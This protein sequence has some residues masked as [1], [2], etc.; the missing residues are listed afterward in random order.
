MTTVLVIGANRGIGLEFVKQFLERGDKVLATCRSKGSAGDLTALG[1]AAGQLQVFEVDV[2]HEESIAGLAASLK[3]A[4]GGEGIDLLIHNA[5]V[6]G[7]RGGAVEDLD[8]D[9]WAEVLR[10]NSIAPLLITR[11]LLDLLRAGKTAKAERKLVYI[12]SKMGSMGDNEGGGSYIYRSSKAALNAAVKSLAIDL[13]AENFLVGLLHPG[14][15]QT[16]M[17]GP[18]ALIDTATSVA[19][20]LKLIDGLSA[21]TSGKFFAYDGKAIPW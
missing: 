17:G 3:K 12:T 9:A 19:G 4:L 16:D 18:S 10:V 1:A 21:K 5:G 15:V 6:Y 7:P 11:H 2:Q 14:W 8:G 20:M 13:S